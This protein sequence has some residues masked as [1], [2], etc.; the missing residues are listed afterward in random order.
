M[1]EHQ[2]SRTLVKS[3]PELW[4]ECSDPL[5]LARHLDPLG[6]L[7]EVRITRLEPETTVA[8]EGVR[9]SGTVALEPAG[10]G[11]KV[12]LTARSDQFKGEATSMTSEAPRSASAAPP[13]D[14]GAVA[15]SRTDAGV[16]ARP[17][18]SA[19][20]N[21]APR[22]GLLERLGSFFRRPPRSISREAVDDP[23]PAVAAEPTAPGAAGAAEPA[24]VDP[25]PPEL[26][27]DSILTTVLE[28]LGQAHRRP[29]SRT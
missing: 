25:E 28:S 27:A 3:Q 22:R 5:S 8:W 21:R 26:D 17:A 16:E 6:Q 7:G 14:E 10:W 11:T 9:A 4:A 24:P 23:D 19:S 2:T 18:D 12:T 13:R 20:S 15:L 29:F 1:T